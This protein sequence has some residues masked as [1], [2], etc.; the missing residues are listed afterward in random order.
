MM[1]TP[2]I[3]LMAILSVS[4]CSPAAAPS[5]PTP[6]ATPQ[7]EASTTPETAA[8]ETPAPEAP[9]PAIVETLPQQPA[10]VEIPAQPMQEAAS[11]LDPRLV[12]VWVNE[13]QINSPGGAGGFA[14]LSTVMTME[15]HPDGAIVQYTQSVGG[16]SEWSSNSG[17][18][19]DFEGKWRASNNTLFVLGMGLTDYTAAGTYSFSGAYLVTNNNL[20]RLIWQ[21]RG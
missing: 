9:T 12:G 5:E 18:K 10:P 3:G 6:E 17:R 13:K 2:I 11:Q 20:G 4:G 8:P 21:K 14:S 1:A 19:L 7:A 16:G 15:I